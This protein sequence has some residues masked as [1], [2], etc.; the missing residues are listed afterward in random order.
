MMR[1]AFTCFLLLFFAKIGFSQ[2]GSI[3]GTVLDK[4]YNDV[5]FGAT[6]QIDGTA[7]GTTT[8][9]DGKYTLRGIRPGTYKLRFSMLSYKTVIIESVKVEAG[10]PT[11]VDIGME[12]DAN[13][14]G[15]VEVFAEAP[16]NTVAADV[17]TMKEADQVVNVI[18]RQTIGST[19]ASTAAD[20]AKMI[21]GVT[22]IDNRNV[23]VRG[24]SE[25]YN[26]VMLNNV[27]APSVEADVKVFSFDLVPSG[28]ID[29][30][31]IYKS[32]SPDLPGEFSGGA[33][34]I[35]TQNIPD[36]SALSVMLGTGV[37][38]GTTFEEFKMNKGS[39]TDGFGFDNG[40]RDLPAGFPGNVRKYLLDHPSEGES[41]T[42]MLNNN[43]DYETGNA[44]VDKRFGVVLMNRFSPVDSAKGRQK[45]QFGNIT[46]LNYSNS[47]QFYNSQRLDYNT[48]NMQTQESDTVFNYSDDVFTNKVRVGILQNNSIRF[49]KH[50]GH[51]VELKN[52]FNQLGDNE[53]ILRGGS[54]IEFGETRREYSYHYTERS[55]Y[56]GQLSGY[57]EFNRDTTHEDLTKLDWTAGYSFAK[58]NEPDWRRARYS[59][60]FDTVSFPNYE[61]YLPF[62][63]TP[64][65]LGRIFINMDESVT[66]GAVNAEHK[67]KFRD[68]TKKDS[69]R[70]WFTLKAGLYYENKERTFGVRNIGY[71]P[72]NVFYFDWTQL[73]KPLSEI[74][75]NT[76]D[77]TG[78]V[79]D[80]DTKL[81]DQ[82]TASNNLLAGYA[83][84]VVPMLKE[85]L[86]LTGGVRLEKN[87]QQLNSHK[88][89][90][91]EEIN[92]KN[93]IL[94]VLPS[95]NVSY[96]FTKKMLVRA[97]YGRTVNRP[98]FREIAPF[99]FYD[100]AFN[101]IYAGNDSLQTPV[102]DN[103]DL[104][105]ELYP[106]A[107]EN[108]TFGVFYKKFTNPIE[109]YFVPG[110]G[111]GGTRSFTWGNAPKAVSYGAEIEVRKK[112]D[113]IGV[114]FI[115][116][117]TLVGNAAYIF[118]NITLTDDTAGV[119]QNLQTRPMMGQSPYIANGGIYYKN[120][121]IGLQV[122]VLYN[123]V[124]P[125]VVIVGIPG[126]PEV[127]EMPRHNLDLT[128]IKTFGRKK[129]ME[130]R[131]G[132]QDIFNAPCLLLQ[133]ANEDGKLDR[134]GDQVMQSYRRGTYFTLG[135]TVRTG[136]GK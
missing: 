84:G 7:V 112:L 128:V 66:A 108:L 49:G 96:N 136:L 121:S 45:F 114:P 83:M 80:E 105:W 117:L 4:T 55:I 81:A 43:W 19:N 126:L 20:V 70:Y 6:V 2:T 13:N 9:F 44:P 48:Y 67:F 11:R 36:S 88:T 98:E 97:G 76:D 74:F 40:Y 111:T 52:L 101:S 123:V 8:D 14:I 130:A 31:M 42:N 73:S 91:T 109:I 18:G 85:K 135:F 95:G 34:K 100:F 120:D 131:L 59:R 63:A 10:K 33:I 125:R 94:S 133:D 92:V 110:V 22:V 62:Q 99:T 65:F 106:S 87:V 12:V 53:T 129:N 69:T 64:S 119:Q 118:S 17:K 23:V 21:P 38:S 60:S 1:A 28:L 107:T 41:T 72:S 90:S 116:N 75:S 27:L 54:N 16:K 68:D 47:S 46:A 113:S 104:R 5:M 61:L 115:R 124:G 50:A 93:D 79:I 26:A 132:I 15:L 102:I 82:Y 39:K 71:R 25:R 103:Y 77:S 30:F 78:I 122:N 51:K 32:P 134:K 58:R 86:R 3:T 24:L 37:R 57:H 127:W 35:F 29:R 89:N 56:S